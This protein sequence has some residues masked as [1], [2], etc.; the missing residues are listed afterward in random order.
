MEHEHHSSNSTPD[1]SIF[2]RAEGVDIYAGPMF[3]GVTETTPTLVEYW[4]RIEEDKQVA[5]LRCHTC[6]EMHHPR[7]V[8]CTEC[9][10]WDLRYQ[11]VRGGGEVYSFTTVH[12]APVPE[13]AGD[14]PYTIGIVMLEEGVALF[15]RIFGD[16]EDLPIE[17]GAK[18][19]VSVERLGKYMLP[20][21]HVS[22]RAPAR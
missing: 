22:E 12:Q 8:V 9:W 7:A 13:A 6:G 15:G 10:E 18:V 4:R 2:R 19:R 5:V 16:D 11:N 21:F 14:V 20:V 1:W 17:I 3:R